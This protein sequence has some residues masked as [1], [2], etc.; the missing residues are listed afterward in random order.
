VAG[1]ARVAAKGVKIVA[2][3]QHSGVFVGIAAAETARF[4]DFWESVLTITAPVPVEVR[5]E[6]GG[7]VARNRNRLTERFLASEKEWLWYLDDDQV[8]LPGTLPQLLKHGV[9]VVSGLYVSRNYPFLP[10]VYGEAREDGRAQLKECRHETGRMQVEAVGA[11]CLLVNRAVIQQLTPPYWTLGQVEPDALSDDLEFCR[12]VR[13]A[14]YPIW[15]DF[16]TRV[17]HKSQCALWPERSD[18]GWGTTLVTGN[19][20]VCHLRPPT[21]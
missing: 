7:N 17:G 19:R 8:L 15:V 16:D 6:R 11:G 10:L 4:T 21:S 1:P 3:S 14:G 9:S 20:P 2:V 13:Q 5:V 12:R 18:A